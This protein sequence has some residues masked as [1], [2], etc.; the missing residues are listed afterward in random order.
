M[1]HAFLV[2][3]FGLHIVDGVRGLDIQG[4]GLPGP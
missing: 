1:D 2:L 4:N 3:D